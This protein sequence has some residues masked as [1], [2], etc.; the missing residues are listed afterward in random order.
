[1]SA[2]IKNFLIELIETLVTSFAIL[3]LI[4]LFIA[5][6]EV[7]FGASMEPTL[8]TGERI[9]VERLTNR[10]GEYERGDVV[11][12]NPPGNDSDDYVK[13][14]IGMP[15]EIVKVIDCNVYVS[16]DGKKYV[17]QEPYLDESTCTIGGLTLRNGR[18]VIL[19]ENDY[20]VLG[21]NRSRSADSR[22]FGLVEEERILGKVVLRFWP[23]TK[24]KFF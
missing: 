10:F 16:K 4:Y 12:L 23:V 5:F 3:L 6:P 21:D 20:F 9:L 11:V 17:L 15:G 18:S 14:V 13:R 24:L 2:E 1:M 7:V 22:V 19:D 8:H